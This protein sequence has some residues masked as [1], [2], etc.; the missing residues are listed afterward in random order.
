MLA[1]TLTI[2][3]VVLA[4]CAQKAGIKTLT[5]DKFK[6]LLT[7]EDVQKVIIAEV[8]LETH[9]FDLK[10]MVETRNP[11]KVAAID[12]SYSLTLQT[13]DGRKTI[14][15]SVVDFNSQASAQ[16]RFEEIKSETGGQCIMDPPIGDASIEVELDIH[17]MGM[18][19]FI[20]GDKV[21]ELINTRTYDDKPLTSL[22]GLR[23]LA[24]IVEERLR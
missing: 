5:E 20:K 24:E 2:L 12:S 10:K 9:L 18:I 3:M 7:V 15:L 4:G 14:A 13:Y 11:E 1:L 6:T 17:G 8:P 23:Q 21:I 16:E 19:I 22:E